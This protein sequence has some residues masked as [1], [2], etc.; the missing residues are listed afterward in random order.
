ME[1]TNKWFALISG[2][3]EHGKCTI[4]RSSLMFIFK[5]FSK[6]YKTVSKNITHKNYEIKEHLPF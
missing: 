6:S 3:I 2:L 4:N 1:I 5:G